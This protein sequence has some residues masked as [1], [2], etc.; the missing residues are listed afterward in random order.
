MQISTP[1]LVAHRGFAAAYPENTLLAIRAAVEAGARWVEFDVQLSADQIPVL[2]HDRDLQ[3]MCGR[4]GHIHEYTLAQL[5]TLSAQEF[6]KFGY[7]YV[8]NP[9]TS[10]VEL[11]AYITTQP[12]VG[13]FVELKRISLKQF[14]IATVVSKVLE[15]LTAIQ[16]QAVI[17]SY[18]FAALAVVRAQSDYPIGAVFDRWRERHSPSL[19]KLSPEYLFTDIERLPRWGKLRYGN[20]KIGVYECVD[21]DRALR[22]FV[23]GVDLVETFAID[24]MLTQIKL[25]TPVA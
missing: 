14:G 4:S 15:Q 24:P 22:L 6:G 18:D 10:L 5:K 1:A 21:P 20:S 17:I 8:G 19:K 23:R 13:V 16:S 11:V 3:R 2:F 9:L 7:K 25:R 12:Q